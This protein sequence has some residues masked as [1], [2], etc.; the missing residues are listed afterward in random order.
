MAAIADLLQELQAKVGMA[1]ILITHDLGVVAEVAD[2]VV[3]MYAGQ[4]AEQGTV[5]EIFA[6]PKHPYTRGL[7]NSIPTLSQDPTGKVKKKRLETIPGIVPNLL[8]L[9]QGCRFQD[10]CTFVTDGCK[11]KSIDLRTIAQQPIMPHA[12]RCVR[13][14]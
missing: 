14:I 1:M 11:E 7:L 12:I 10:R 2:E 5:K 6:S 4:V 3:V 8:H 9:P 13:D